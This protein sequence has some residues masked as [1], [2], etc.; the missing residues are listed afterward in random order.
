[1]EHFLPAD[2]L[3]PNR[4]THYHLAHQVLSALRLG[5]IQIALLVIIPLL[6]VTVAIVVGALA[7]PTFRA[8]AKILVPTGY[9]HAYRPIIGDRMAVAPW[10]NEVAINAERE[11]LNS[12]SLKTEVVRQIGPGAILSTGE[13]ADILTGSKLQELKE[14][15]KGLLRKLRL[16]QPRVS[17]FEKA[18][19]YLNKE[20]EI[21]SVVDSNVIHLYFQHKDRDMAS[22]VLEVFLQAYLEHRSK[23][24]APPNL[25]TLE[26]V[27]KRWHKVVADAQQR[28]MAY[29]AQHEI[30]DKIAIE[31]LEEDLRNS[32][33][34]LQTTRDKIEDVRLERTLADAQWTTVRIIEPSFTP[35]KPEG[36]PPLVRI[37]L[38]AALGF[39]AAITLI[40]GYQQIALF[41]SSAAQFAH[42][43]SSALSGQDPRKP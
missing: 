41:R 32:R 38:A 36:L 22:R 8:I 15:L 13:G 29:K 19:N 9:E 43:D 31:T 20:L 24:Y 23:L 12:R 42:S 30:P 37:F 39:I 35:Q 28:L 1:M 16:K 27:L 17:K 10:K 34:R 3:E 26:S 6:S 5:R 25:T 21:S 11:I 18:V 40:V 4:R 2:P 7:Q 33:R 14:S